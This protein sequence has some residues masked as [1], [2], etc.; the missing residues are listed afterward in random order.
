[1]AGGGYL[2]QVLADALS[3]DGRALRSVR[4]LVLRPGHLTLEFMAGRRVRHTEPAQLYLLAAAAFFLVNAYRPFITFDVRTLQVRSA[5]NT[6]TLG[7]GLPAARAAELAAR[8]AD[9]GALE[10]FRERFE[11]VASGFLPPL[12]LAS[13]LL[14]AG[15]LRLLRPRAPRGVHVVFALHWSAFFLLSMIVAR[16]LPAT[17]GRD[18]LGAVIALLGLAWLAVAVRR[19]YGHG[20]VGAA[21]TAVA[22]KVAF[23][24]VLAGWMFAA[25]SAGFAL[26]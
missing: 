6:I 22:L 8:A 1:M 7:L 26:A 14:F 20:W 10:V 15:M 24:L 25:I 21:L 17:G 9:G 12:L 11:N 23:Y 5:L 16:L 2:R 13:V 18:P 3:I 4:D 19:V